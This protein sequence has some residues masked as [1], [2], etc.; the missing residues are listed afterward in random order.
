MDKG[1]STYYGFEGNWKERFNKIKKTGFT[2]YITSLDT[3]FDKQNGKISKQVKYAKK[4]GL[5]QS[6][7]HASYDAKNLHNFWLENKKG[8]KLEK[9]L[10]KEVKIAKKLGFRC[11]VVHLKGVPSEVGIKRLERIL[12]ICE[13]I[14]LPIAIENLKNVEIIKHIREN[15]SSPYLKFCF[16]SGHQNLFNKETDFLELMQND[17][18]ALHLH[19][20]MGI[21][22]DHTLKEFG[23]I[24][25]CELAQKLSKIEDISLDFEL[26]NKEKHDKSEEYILATCF[27]N[28]CE[29]EQKI[30]EYKLR[31]KN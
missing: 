7:V 1:I 10:I 9:I 30:K 21:K 3:R 16:D 14:K 18:I 23:N 12:E 8:D 24:N 13:R 27:K 5:K 15:V 29:L 6:S 11:L 25:W 31:N 22:D 28:A 4:I 26:L 2:T 19:D 17:V 20:N